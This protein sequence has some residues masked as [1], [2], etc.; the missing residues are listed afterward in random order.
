MFHSSALSVLSTRNGNFPSNLDSFAVVCWLHSLSLLAEKK[1]KLFPSSTSTFPIIELDDMRGERESETRKTTFRKWKI[2]LKEIGK[3]KR[4]LRAEWGNFLDSE[5]T[6]KSGKFSVI[7]ISYTERS[8]WGWAEKRM[9][10]WKS[11][12]HRIR[13]LNYSDCIMKVEIESFFF[14]IFWHFLNSKLDLCVGI[15]TRLDVHSSLLS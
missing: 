9:E 2:W 11:E 5:K 12:N 6:V 4:Y 1:K 7:R 8:D 10:K 14:Q 13:E 15:S 3:L